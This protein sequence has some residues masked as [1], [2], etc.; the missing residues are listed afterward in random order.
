MCWLEPA[1]L[2][3]GLATHQYQLLMKKGVGVEVGLRVGDHDS[4]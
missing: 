3:P 4:L 1:G 2:T